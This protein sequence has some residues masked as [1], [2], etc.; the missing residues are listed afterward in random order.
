MDNMAQSEIIQIIVPLL[1]NWLIFRKN[2]PK[3]D[4]EDLFGKGDP[5]EAEKKSL[6]TMLTY[7]RGKNKKDGDEMKDGL[8]EIIRRKMSDGFEE[9]D[10]QMEDQIEEKKA[11]IN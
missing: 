10:A 4:E 6:M 8:M 2:P 9:E 7:I 3:L 5:K 1:T 11:E